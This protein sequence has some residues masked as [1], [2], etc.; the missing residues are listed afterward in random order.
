MRVATLI[1]GLV[2][3]LGVFTQSLIAAAGGGLTDDQELSNAAGWGVLVA[4]GFLVGSATVI[5]KPRF[6][7]WTFAVSG[8]IA[9]IAGATSAFRDLIIWG[10]AALILSGM[11]WRGAVE[12]H[13]KDAADTELLDAAAALRRERVTG[14][15]AQ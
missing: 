4:L 13:R 2:L 12:K 7:M 8:V 15:P 5:A 1:I 3:M 6:A 9:I 10:V 11:A 14:E